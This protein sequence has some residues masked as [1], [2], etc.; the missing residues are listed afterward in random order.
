MVEKGGRKNY[1]MVN[2]TPVLTLWAAVVTEV[3]VGRGGRCPIHSFYFPLF[4]F[5]IPAENAPKQT[6]D[7]VLKSL[8]KS[9]DPKIYLLYIQPTPKRVLSAPGK[10]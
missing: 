6:Q 4:S 5:L 1:V 3:F 10:V 9:L 8:L 7:L 2:H